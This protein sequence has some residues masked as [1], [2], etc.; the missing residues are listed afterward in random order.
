MF[1]HIFPN[2]NEQKRTLVTL[3]GLSFCVTANLCSTENL[4]FS[5]TNQNPE[6]RRPFGTGLVRHCP[7]GLFS[8]FFTFFFVPYFSAFLDFPSPPLSAPGSPRMEPR[9]LI[10]WILSSNLKEWQ[11]LSQSVLVK[12]SSPKNPFIQSN[13]KYIKL[14]NSKLF[15]N[16][17]IYHENYFTQFP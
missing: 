8:P 11:I 17:Q 10:A 2:V 1:G 6:R 3:T 13:M 7:Q 15:E 9:Q 16:S 5:G 14:Y 4:C 12:R